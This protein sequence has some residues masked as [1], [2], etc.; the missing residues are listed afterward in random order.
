MILP[1]LR[2]Q[3]KLVRWGGVVSRRGTDQISKLSD[4]NLKSDF[5]FNDFS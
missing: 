4:A 3:E 2:K 5:K 1:W